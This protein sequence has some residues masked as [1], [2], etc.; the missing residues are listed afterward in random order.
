VD[1]ARAPSDD[2]EQGLVFAQNPDP[3]IEADKGSMVQITVSTGPEQVTVPG[4]VEDDEE[5][6]R[7][8]LED[9]GFDVQ[10]EDVE[11]DDETQDG[12]VF[13]QDPDG[14]TKADPGSVVTILVGR[15]T[16]E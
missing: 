4:V 3:G 9:A 13:E 8:R 10:V 11:T 12:I 1:V 16:D 6:A 2:V 15:F 7:Q 5:T 14:G